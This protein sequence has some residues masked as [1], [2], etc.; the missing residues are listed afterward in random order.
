[1]VNARHTVGRWWP[2]IKHEWLITFA[3]FHTF[4]K[5]VVLLPK[6]KHLVSYRWEVQMLV[7]V[8]LLRHACSEK[9]REDKKPS[10]SDELVLKPLYGSDH[11]EFNC[12]WSWQAVD[13]NGCTAR[14]V[15]LEV[16]RINAIV[17]LEVIFHISQKNGYVYDLI[18]AGTRIFKDQTDVLEYGMT[19]LFDVVRYDIAIII[20]FYTWNFLGATLSWTNS[21]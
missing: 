8:V 12:Y 3:G 18:P 9:V 17:G 16:F 20:Q 2:F 15:I 14:L 19:L 7:F 1:M 4:S 11:F 10:A 5:D 21:G 13:F 6:V